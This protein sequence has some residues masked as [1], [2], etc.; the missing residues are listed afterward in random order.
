MTSPEEKCPHPIRRIVVWDK[1]NQRGCSPEQ[2]LSFRA[3]TVAF[4][5]KGATDTQKIVSRAIKF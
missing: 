5:Y 1:E 3:S 2:L 4:I